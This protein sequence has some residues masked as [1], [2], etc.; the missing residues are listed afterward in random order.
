MQ[1]CKA[2]LGWVVGDFFTYRFGERGQ[3]EEKKKVPSVSGGTAFA[4][5]E[6]RLAGS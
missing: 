1:I 4:V 6:P 3:R 2:G 5:S